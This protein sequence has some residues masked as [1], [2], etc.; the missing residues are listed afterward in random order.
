MIEDDD[1]PRGSSFLSKNQRG[2]DELMSLLP[3]S[4]DVLGTLVIFSGTNN[5]CYFLQFWWIENWVEGIL[6]GH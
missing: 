4:F 5:A 6:P 1:D 2:F 3:S